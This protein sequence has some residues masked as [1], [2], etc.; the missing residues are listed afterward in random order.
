[1]QAIAEVSATCV[2]S[3]SGSAT[4][5]GCAYSSAYA[6]ASAK[7]FAVAHAE[8]TAT[9][10]TLCSCGYDFVEVFADA[11]V[12]IKLWAEVHAAAQAAACAQGALP[13][14]CLTRLATCSAAGGGRVLA[15]SPA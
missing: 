15:L 1:M 2:T 14:I 12:V 3:T 5:L 4:A 10:S 8:A 9:A 13:R 6:E 11:D 7:A